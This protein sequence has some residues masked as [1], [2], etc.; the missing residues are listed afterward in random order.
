[1]SVV[2]SPAPEDLAT[3][4]DWSAWY[5]TDED[6]MGQSPEQSAIVNVFLGA[7]KVR[8]EELGWNEAYVDFDQFFGWVPSEPL[9][10]ISPDAFVLRD[11]PPFPLPASWQVWRHGHH[12][13]TFAL[14]VVSQDWRK[15]YHEIPQKYAHL[16][17][18]ELVIYDP[19]AADRQTRVEERVPIQLYWRAPDGLFVC[20]YTGEGPVESSVLGVHL[21]IVRTETWSFLRLAYDPEGRHLVPTEVERA[22][23][24]RD[25]AARQRDEAARQRDEATRQRDEAARQRDE[26]T[27]QRDAERVAR[28]ALAEELAALRAKVGDSKP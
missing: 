12:A 7:L 14:E 15:D 10:R 3:T 26:A 1:L 11:P 19:A 9:V 28:E 21:V 4:I 5:L 27:R 16:G 17:V 24:A 23:N 25:E 8:A 22:E 13:P 20:R 2:R 18:E 6:D